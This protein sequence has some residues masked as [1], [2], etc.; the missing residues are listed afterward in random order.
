MSIWRI[1]S[2]HEE[3]LS[4]HIWV[5]SKMSLI[6]KPSHDD[7]KPN[8]TIKFHYKNKR[9]LYDTN[10]LFKVVFQRGWWSW[11][12]KA[13]QP[14]AVLLAICYRRRRSYRAWIGSQQLTHPSTRSCSSNSSWVLVGSYS[15]RVHCS[16][17]APSPI[18]HWISP[19]LLLC[20]SLAFHSQL[21][22]NNTQQRQWDLVL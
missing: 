11:L 21:P 9:K 5:K 14:Q 15:I 2:S 1:K 16:S 3:N 7:K 18:S 8:T 6:H 12:S 10:W 22:A 4:S 13:W 20:V 17:P 19:L